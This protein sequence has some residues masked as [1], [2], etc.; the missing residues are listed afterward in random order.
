[1]SRYNA[2]M[3]KPQTTNTL[4]RKARVLKKNINLMPTK[5]EALRKECEEEKQKAVSQE[6][7]NNLK[8]ILAELDKLSAQVQSWSSF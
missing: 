3:T 6:K 2:G 4:A 5:I 7:K 8:K 1:M